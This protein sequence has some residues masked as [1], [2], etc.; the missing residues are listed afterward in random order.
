MPSEN[1][2]K[3]AK[4]GHFFAGI[5]IGA[6]L[7]LL[8]LLF[9]GALTHD[10]LYWHDESAKILKYKSEFY[11]LTPMKLTLTEP[12]EKEFKGEQDAK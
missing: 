3:E 6:L 5:L 7:M 4:L 2:I 11:K 10:G 9:Y 8:I 12:K 1:E